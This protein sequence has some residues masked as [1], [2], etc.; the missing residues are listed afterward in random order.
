MLLY[1]IL[2]IWA[3]S[4]TLRYLILIIIHKIIKTKLFAFRLRCLL[5]PIRKCILYLFWFLIPVW[6]I[7]MVLKLI[8]CIHMSRR[9]TFWS[10]A[11]FIKWCYSLFLS[12]FE[13]ILMRWSFRAIKL[14]IGNIRHLRHS[15]KIKLN[16]YLSIFLNFLQCLVSLLVLLS[17]I[18]VKCKWLFSTSLHFH[19]FLILI[20]FFLY[21]RYL[22]QIW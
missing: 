11:S 7:I 13:L 18:I 5:L 15:V 2:W 12:T 19:F 4:I 10:N 1:F 21:F 22:Y 17:L 9:N 16:N 6:K 14:R 3:S 20:F 8:K